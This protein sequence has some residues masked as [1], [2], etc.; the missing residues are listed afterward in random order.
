MKKKTDTISSMKEIVNYT[1]ETFQIYIFEK[2]EVNHVAS[3]NIT[4]DG[5]HMIIGVKMTRPLQLLL[6]EKVLKQLPTIWE[7]LPITNTWEVS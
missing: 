4:K 3:D 2:P 6:R 5:I 7:D 1:E